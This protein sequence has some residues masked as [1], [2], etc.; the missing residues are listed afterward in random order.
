MSNKCTKYSSSDL[1]FYI[2]GKMSREQE[3]ELQ[4]HI[5]SCEECMSELESLRSA[6]NSI[7]ESVPNT[8]GGSIRRIYLI[9]ASIAAVAVGGLF[10]ILN[11]DSE[12]GSMSPLIYESA[13]IYNSSDKIIQHDSL[14]IDSLRRDSLH[15]D[16]IQIEIE[17]RK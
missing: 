11:W 4:H 8:T 7:E 2:R 9:A 16:S 14:Q 6:V 3:L 17:I 15:R 13:P 10:S 1:M 12:G 5:L